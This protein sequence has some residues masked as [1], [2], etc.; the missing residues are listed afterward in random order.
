MHLAYIVYRFVLLC[1]SG[2][3]GFSAQSKY[4]VIERQLNGGRDAAGISQQ[5]RYFQHIAS[6][7]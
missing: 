3:S 1:R 5:R 4:W 7:D 2:G 6:E